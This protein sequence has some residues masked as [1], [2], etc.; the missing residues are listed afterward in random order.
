MERH[1]SVHDKVK[2]YTCN[3][4]KKE[5]TAPSKLKRHEKVHEP[6]N[7]DNREN[8]DSYPCDKCDKTYTQKRYMIKHMKT[9]EEFIKP[10]EKVTE[11]ILTKYLSDKP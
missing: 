1:L 2:D 11:K 5:F 9:H 10:V 8:V 7:S 6:S 4:C 3:V